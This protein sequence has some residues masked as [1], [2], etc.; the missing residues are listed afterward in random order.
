MTPIAALASVWSA[1]VSSADSSGSTLGAG[2][3]LVNLKSFA[4]LHESGGSAFLEAGWT[5]SE[6]A[7]AEG[8]SERLAA[9]WAAK[10]AVMKALRRGLGDVDPLDVEILT[11][12]SGAPLVVL[13]RSALQVANALGV[14]EWH[15][16]MCHEEGWAA[17]LAIAERVLPTH[18]ATPPHEGSP[19]A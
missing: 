15:I 11:A 16:S 17:A 13:H 4:A 1:A 12:S 8:S 3:D 2:F 14:A 6:R 5:A 18:C 10:E 7:D 19:H 9:R